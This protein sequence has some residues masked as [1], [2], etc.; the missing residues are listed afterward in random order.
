MRQARYQNPD[1]AWDLE[2]FAQRER[3]KEFVL[4]FESALCVYSPTVELLYATYEMLFTEDADNRLVILPDKNAY[5]DTFTRISGEWVKPTGLYI[6]PGELVGRQGMHLANV[7]AER[8]ITGRQIPF[9]AGL[10]AIMA[11][12]PNPDPF[13]PV[14]T[15]GDLREFEESWPVLHLHR[16]CLPGLT[17]LSELDR[18]TMANVIA[19]K[20]GS[21]IQAQSRNDMQAAVA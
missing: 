14:L 9:V 3:A 15:K 21:L 13:L 6:V 10:R 2:Q 7:S 16:I 12:R 1:L 20:L 11:A 4:Q 19:E 5:Y 18:S 8:T 17:H